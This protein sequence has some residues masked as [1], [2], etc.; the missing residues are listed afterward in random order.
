LKQGRPDLASGH[1]RQALA[2]KPDLAT[3]QSNLLF[4]LNYDPD[5]DPDTVFAEHRRQGK[6]IEA[7]AQI[8]TADRSPHIGNSPERRLRVG[9]ISPDLRYHPLSRYFEP[10]LAHHDPE[11]VETFCYAEV[12]F[13]DSVTKRLEKLA[14]GWY[15]TCHQTDAQVAQ[16]IRADK[17]EILV[18]LA[19]HTANNRLGVLAYKPAPIQATWLGYMN[20]TGLSC[21]DYRITDDVLD[22][23]GEPVRDTEELLRLPSGM[24]CFAPPAEAPE[25]SCLPAKRRGYVTFGSLHNLFKLNGKVFDLWSQI[26]QA[27]PDAR[28]LVFRDMMTETARNSIRRLFEQRGIPADRL[29][30]RKGVSNP[31]YL[32]VYGEIDISLDAFPCTG[33]VTTCE[34]LWMGVPM[35]TLCGVRPAGRNAAALLTHARLSDWISR[36]K[37]EYV[38]IAVDSAN[39]LDQ[40]AKLR[41]SLREQMMATLCDAKR[42]TPQLEDAYRTMWRKWCA[43]S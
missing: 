15:S 29:D 13:P 4:C 9:Y 35:L 22:P 8:M 10:V 24:C 7:R 5:V 38:R 14:H 17:I 39:S 33:G 43:K 36:T 27:L 6:Q 21:V 1:F 40:L 11:K 41:S 18:D 16:R 28:L 31:S 30:L 26:L 12:L 19:G 2:L 3:A 20:T 42:F 25:V 23:V 34:S 37:E 32:S